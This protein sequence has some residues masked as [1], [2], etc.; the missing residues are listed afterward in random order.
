MRHFRKKL[1]L[2]AVKKNY[3]KCQFGKP[4]VETETTVRKRTKN[5]VTDEKT[6]PPRRSSALPGRPVEAKI[7]KN[8]TFSPSGDA[9]NAPQGI[10]WFAPCERRASAGPAKRIHRR[11]H[12]R[13]CKALPAKTGADF[14]RKFQSLVVLR[15]SCPPVPSN[16]AVSHGATD[17]KGP[18]GRPYSRVR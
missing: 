3:D 12:N 16:A 6:R 1:I 18:I 5:R 17:R 4:D 11:R 10:V 9:E 13:Q 2:L 8:A 14:G 15:A 7:A